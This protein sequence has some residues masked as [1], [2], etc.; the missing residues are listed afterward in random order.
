MILEDYKASLNDELQHYG[1][2]GQ[3]KGERHYQTY[4]GKYTEEGKIRYGRIKPKKVFVSGS[5]KTQDTES[6]YY[7]EKL[8]K[9]VRTQLKEIMKRNKTILVGDAPGIDRQ[10]QDFINSMGYKKVE[11][12]GPGK[13]VRYTANKKWKTNPIDAPEFEEYSPEWLRAKDIAMTNEATEG[14][15][16]ILD[17]GAKATHNNVER[18]QSQNKKVKV[19]QLNKTGKDSWVK[20]SE[21]DDEGLQH[22]GV[23][24]MRWGVRRYQN[25]D[26]SLTPLGRI[27]YGRQLK[28][29]QRKGYL[30]E[31]GM[32][33]I[34]GYNKLSKKDEKWV[35]KNYD[36]IYRQAMKEST[37]EMKEYRE[38]YL[39]RKYSEQIKNR[40]VG[41]SYVNEYNKKLAEVLNEKV[42]DVRTPNLEKVVSFIAKRGELGAHMAISDQGYDLS[43]FKN[44][45]YRGGRVAY[46][47]NTVNSI[48]AYNR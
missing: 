47:K 40:R 44:G 2:K 34:K 13:E 3:K 18:L 17:E 21:E 32:L 12:Y 29:W 14:L 11:V 1:I 30:D 19:F 23:M 24:G 28:K 31:N 15:A 46:R 20:H 9:Q 5:S 39:N 7:R 43:Q 27:H 16:V 45:I 42:S 37:K 6:G 8:P 26:G 33:N 10:V 38:N 41:L 36:K 35:S 22:S 25:E 48:P 4:D